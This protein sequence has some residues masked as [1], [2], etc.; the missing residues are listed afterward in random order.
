MLRFE[1]DVWY[2]KQK[3]FSV[4]EIINY[5]R[6]F[7]FQFRH[8]VFCSV[9]IILCLTIFFSVRLF[10]FMFC[11]YILCSAIFCVWPLCVCI[12][13]FSFYVPPLCSDIFSSVYTT[14]ASCKC[15]KYPLF[16]INGVLLKSCFATL[17]NPKEGG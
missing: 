6:N 3:L 16:C 1:E 13:P 2:T 4:S 9:I 12:R 10:S 17:T 14:N 5:L 7:V 8:F 15:T 11:N